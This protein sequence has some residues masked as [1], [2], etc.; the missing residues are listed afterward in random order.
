M[1]VLDGCT[2]AL[3]VPGIGKDEYGICDAGLAETRCFDCS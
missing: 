2:T 1:L 3:M